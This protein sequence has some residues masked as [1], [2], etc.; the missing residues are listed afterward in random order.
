MAADHKKHQHS[1]IIKI[2]CKFETIATIDLN[3]MWHLMIKKSNHNYESIFAISHS[4]LRK[5][6]IIF[7]IKQNIEAQSKLDVS[8]QKIVSGLRIDDDDENPRFLVKDIYN[9]KAMIKRK[10][11]RSLTLIQI[12]L[13]NL[14]RDDWYYKHEINDHNQI[15]IFDQLFFLI[16][17]C[18][19]SS[20]PFSSVKNSHISCW[21]RIERCY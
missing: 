12:L 14:D 11:L 17:W 16:N 8:S 13:R 3:D 21:K 7:E 6:A 2:E 9:A 18:N 19:F 1:T 5:S 10:N 20:N 4:A 15:W